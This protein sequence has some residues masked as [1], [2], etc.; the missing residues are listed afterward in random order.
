MAINCKFHENKRN[1]KRTRTQRTY[2]AYVNQEFLVRSYISVN[3]RMMNVQL[4]FKIHCREYY[5]GKNGRSD[6][7][8]NPNLMLTETSVVQ[9]LASN[10][11]RV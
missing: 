1:G 9:T 3:E 8:R 2:R 11:Y 10:D 5:H 7:N 6:R 4:S